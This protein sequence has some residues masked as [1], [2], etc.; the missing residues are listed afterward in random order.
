MWLPIKH[1]THV[2]SPILE[3]YE[4]A[5]VEVLI[6]EDTQTWN[7]DIING[8]FVLEEAKLIKKIPLSRHPI[9]DILFWLWTQSGQ[10]SCKY[11]YRLL[12]RKLRGRV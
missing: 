10:Y 2:S 8:L 11:E 3:G 1:P 12:K 7:E 5:A 4:E 6:N 9:E